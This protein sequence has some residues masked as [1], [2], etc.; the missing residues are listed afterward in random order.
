[1]RVPRAKPIAFPLAR[2]DLSGNEEKYVV[3]A[4]REAGISS[5]GRHVGLFENAF[6]RAVGVPHALAV[7]S[8]TAALHL[9]FAALGVGPGDEVVLPDLTYVATANAVRYTGARVVLVDVDPATW[10]IDPALAAK[11]VSKRTK[12]IVAVHLY[13]NPAAMDELGALAR[14]EGIFLVEDAAQAFGADWRGRRAGALGDV[15]G[16]SL[17]G[18]KVITTGEGGVVVTRSK[19]LEER[20]RRLRDHATSRDRRYYHTQVGFNYRLSALQAALGLAQLERWRQF[21]DKRRRIAEWYRSSLAGVGDLCEPAVPAAAHA[22]SW[23][24]TFR[25]QRWRRSR[26]DACLERM[27]QRGVDARPV[28]V[29]MSAMPM[30]RRA[31]LAV[32]RSLSAQGISLPTHTAMGERD[33][34]RIAAIFRQA[35]RT[36]G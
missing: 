33:V 6:A 4:L 34:K 35:A 14:R 20:L 28:F 24:F 31:G 29:P 22:V 25:M 27:R 1:V 13:G 36:V 16:F 21:V 11:A 10:T 8:G 26:R 17:Y 12:A 5:I 7:T 2:P 15:G 18:N 30:Y 32:A 3:R 23:L 9:A 19:K